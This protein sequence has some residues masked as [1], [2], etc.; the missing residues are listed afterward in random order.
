MRKAKVYHDS[1]FCGLLEESDNGYRFT[2][3]DEWFQ[4]IGQKV[5]ESPKFFSFFDG[6]IPEGYLFQEVIRHWNIPTHDRFGI[7]L[8]SGADCIGAVT[9]EEVEE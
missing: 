3:S 8:K 4:D 6:L 9:L 5:Y 2:Y 1:R 7:L